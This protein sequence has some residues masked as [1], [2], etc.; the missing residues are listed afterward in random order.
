MPPKEGPLAPDGIRSEAV[1][2]EVAADR[3]QVLEPVHE[4][5][6]VVEL[7]LEGEIEISQLR[8]VAVK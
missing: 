1:R 6:Q 8:G 4:V 3:W 7:V 5:H 2:L